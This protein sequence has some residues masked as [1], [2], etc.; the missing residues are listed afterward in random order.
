MGSCKVSTLVALQSDDLLWYQATSCNELAAVCII[1]DSDES[2]VLI[3]DLAQQSVASRHDLSSPAILDIVSNSEADRSQRSVAQSSSHLAISIG[4]SV[5]HIDQVHTTVLSITE[6]GAGFELPGVWSPSWDL[7]GR[8]LAV[9]TPAGVS[10]YSI[11]GSCLASLS[12]LP[13]G[14]MESDVHWLPHSSE[15]MWTGEEEGDGPFTR[16]LL[17]FS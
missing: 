15:L 10:V 12:G 4:M 2:E 7:L 13:A 5:A 3:V 9:A 14:G 11:A 1:D 8:F 6:T 16:A 17:R